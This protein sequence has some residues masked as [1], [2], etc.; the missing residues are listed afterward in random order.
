M[1]AAPAPT[2][3]LPPQTALPAI[4]LTEPARDRLVIGL[5][6]W[7]LAVSMLG[8]YPMLGVKGIVVMALITANAGI[9]LLLPASE[10]HFARM[11]CLVMFMMLAVAYYGIFFKPTL[12]IHQATELRE[13]I[14][15][16]LW[17]GHF[18]HKNTAA[19]AM[20]IAAF[21]GLY[22]MRMGSRVAGLAIVALATL[23]L[24][25]TGGKTSSAMLPASL[26]AAFMFEKMRWIR[27]PMVVGGILG[28]NFLVIGA[29]VIRPV[30]DFIASL[31]I[32]ATFT[33]RADIWRLAVDAI[34]QR[35]FTGYGFKG[36]WQ[37]EEL[38]YSGTVETWAVM[39]GHGHN[40]YLD[41]ILTTGLPGL[42]LALVWVLFLP[43]RDISRLDAEQEK[44]PLTRLF[45]RIWLFAL[46]NAG[47]ES[48]FFEGRNIVWFMLIVALTGLRLQSRAALAS[49]TPKAAELR[50]PAH[51]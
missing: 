28:F 42:V 22:V 26:L 20:V 34:A 29:A 46:F 2:D 24:V 16:G 30:N 21:V 12:S 23:F 1:S 32:D 45:V 44:S 47:L 33:N 41:L 39:A 40:S 14:N 11:I 10:R 50:A 4:A 9:Y 8:S 7:F 6:L 43:L 31:G 18:N 35:P 25:N 48:V 36:F 38:V 17:R 13:P 19:A 37:T 49:E 51:A 15:A 5:L 3:A 27:I